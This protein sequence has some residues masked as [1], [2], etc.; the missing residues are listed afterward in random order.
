MKENAKFLKCPICDNIIEVIDGDVQHITCCGRKME[1]MKANTTDAAIEK[2]IPIYKKVG[3]E[4]VV[5]VGEVEHPEV[6]NLIN[7]SFLL[8]KI[9]RK[10]L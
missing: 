5:S 8:Q 6:L 7:I 4:I 3:D 9:K 10:E 1:E 2:H